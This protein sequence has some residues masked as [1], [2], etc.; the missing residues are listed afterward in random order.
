[1]LDYLLRRIVYIDVSDIRKDS[2][3]L[4]HGIEPISSVIIMFL[5]SAR[6]VAG[7][8]KGTYTGM[9]CIKCRKWVAKKVHINYCRR[10]RPTSQSQMSDRCMSQ[11]DVCLKCILAYKELRK[12]KTESQEQSTVPLYLTC[13]WMPKMTGSPSVYS[14]AHN[15]HN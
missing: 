2:L 12:C 3:C 7:Y 5:L 14:I 15:W 1:M 6:L 11:T 8:V 9:V 10:C 4:P 13:M